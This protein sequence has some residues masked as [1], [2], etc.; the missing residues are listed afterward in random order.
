MQ[1][2]KHHVFMPGETVQG[3]IRKYNRQ[4]LT[5]A[6]LLEL[7]REYDRLNGTTVPRAGEARKVPLLQVP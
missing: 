7:H 4:V 5:P 6:Q 1:K 3:I 2:F